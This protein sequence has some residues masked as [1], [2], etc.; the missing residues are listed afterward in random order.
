MATIP[1]P[2][3]HTA[4]IAQPPNQIEMLGQLMGMKNAQ[5]EMAQRQAMAPLQQQEA[6]Q[7]VQSGQIDLQQKQQ[8]QKDQQA[9]RTAM[10]DP[11]N[12]GKTIGDI[13]DTLAH[14]GAISTQAWGSMKHAEAEQQ[15][16]NASLTD[17]Q[18]KNNKET[19]SQLQSVYNNGMDMTPED[20]QKN[21]G[22]LV[23]QINHIPGVQKMGLDPNQPMT[24]DQL[25]H[26]GTFLTMHNQYL[27]QELARRG[28]V[29]KNQTEDAALQGRQAE[30]Q[31]YQQ[32]GGAPGVPTEMMQQADWLKKNPGKGP[33]DYK[34][35]TLDHTP[36][37]MVMGNMFGP[38]DPGLDMAANNYRQSGQLPAGLARSPGST[39]AII[40]RAAQLDQGAGGAGIAANKAVLG[41][42]TDALKR[43]QTNF[44]QVQAFEQTAEKN[45][46]LLQ[47]TAQKVPD[48]GTR[49]ANVPVRM[50]SAS[51]LGT[52]EMAAFKTALNTAQTEAAKVLNSSNASGVLSD[53]ARHELQDV[54]DGNVP[55]SALVASLNTLKQDMANR[56]Q[57]YQQQIGDLQTRIKG[58][59]GNQQGITVTAP[60]GKVY[61]FK[62]Q[63]SASDFK[64]KAG[65]Q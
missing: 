1:L 34:L 49:F 42:Y 60:N 22:T 20:F 44:S 12:Q 51:A 13:A 62:D 10:Q 16:L 38:G 40:D 54:I 23:G 31:F 11:A 53:S 50:I 3:L 61:T 33:S 65:I 8:Q 26:I 29:T 46:D 58:S 27:D 14:S 48:L 41:S 18:L 47:A 28:M 9:F 52:P 2:A 56:T 15:A 39:K 59:G 55:Y 64:Q 5:Q 36:T 19:T 7:S 6:Q 21:W 37:A 45:M 63:Q 17:T 35:W 4:P 25:S 43:L 30:N 57:S 32:N 24:Q